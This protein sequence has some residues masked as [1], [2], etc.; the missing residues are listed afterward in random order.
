MTLQEARALRRGDKVEITHR[1]FRGE[2]GIVV[3]T[4]RKCSK[5]APT[6]SGY[7]WEVWCS[8]VGRQIVVDCGDIELAK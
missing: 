6:P 1:M 3:V 7:Q 8:G 4:A 2:T 5:H